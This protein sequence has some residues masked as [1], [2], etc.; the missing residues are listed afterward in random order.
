MEALGRIELAYLNVRSVPLLSDELQGLENLA[1][2]EGLEPSA[3]RSKVSRSATELP[4]YG[5]EGGQRSHNLQIQSLTLCQLSYL[6]TLGW[7]TGFE[8]AWDWST[9]N[10]LKPDS[11]T[12]TLGAGTMNRTP[13]SPSSAER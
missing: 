1:G 8:P 3:S 12:A 9:A 6:P 13:F 5:G 2:R 10:R 11:A 7:R 4:A